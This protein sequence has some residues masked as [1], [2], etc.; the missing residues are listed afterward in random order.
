[1]FIS[2]YDQ[3]CDKLGITGKME[4][5]SP[6]GLVHSLRLEIC[7]FE[8]KRH[9][10][11][12]QFLCVCNYVFISQPRSSPSTNY[13]APT[14]GSGW[15]NT[16]SGNYSKPGMPRNSTPAYGNQINSFLESFEYLRFL[17]MN[18]KIVCVFSADAPSPYSPSTPGEHP[19]TPSS[20][21]L[22]ASPDGQPM[23]PGNGALDI[24]SPVVGMFAPPFP[25]PKHFVYSNL[26]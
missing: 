22:P 19:A 15:A 23:T 26:L 21:Y 10:S 11:R 25:R 4:T 18:L 6:G 20:A 12:Y 13:E 2:T 3:Y 14:P 7:P 9:E 16:P 24:M 1:M 5:R 17:I 8:P